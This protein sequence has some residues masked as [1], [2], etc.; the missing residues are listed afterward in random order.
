MCNGVDP[1]S[2]LDLRDQEWR[3]DKDKENS[4]IRTLEWWPAKVRCDAGAIDR[5]IKNE[6]DH[7][8]LMALIKR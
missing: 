7:S 1:Q 4:T 2:K 8:K 3:G 5:Y 6:P